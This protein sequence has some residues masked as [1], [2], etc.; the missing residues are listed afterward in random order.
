MH[1]SKRI[2]SSIMVTVFT[3]F[4]LMSITPLQSMAMV[5][6]T[7]TAAVATNPTP[8]LKGV[9]N[10]Y[11]LGDVVKFTLTSKGYKKT[12]SYRV[13]AVNT[14]TKKNIDVTKGYTKPML[15]AKTTTYQLKALAAGSYT[16]TAYVKVAGVKVSQ[17]KFQKQTFSVYNG[18]ALR[19]ANAKL[20]S[21]TV[22]GDLYIG[23]NNIT[24]SNTR[25][26]GTVYVNPGKNGTTN[27]NNIVA[28]KIKV[29]SGGV[30]SIHFN[31]VSADVLTVDSSSNV[32]VAATGTTQIGNTTIVSYAVLDSKGGTLGTVTIK[33]PANGGVPVVELRGIFPD[34]V[35]IDSNAKVNIT[36]GTDLSSLDIRS[37]ATVTAAVNSNV[38]AVKVDTKDPTAKVALNGEYNNVSVTKEAQVALGENTNIKGQLDIKAS[39]KLTVPKSSSVAKVEINTLSKDAKVDI[40]GST[41]GLIHVSSPANIALAANSKSNIMVDSDGVSIDAAAGATVNLDSKTYDVATTSSDSSQFTKV[42]LASLE[43]SVDDAIAANQ[44]LVV[45]QKESNK[46]ALAQAKK[47]AQAAKDALKNEVAQV[48]GVQL[49]NTDQTPGGGVDQ[50]ALDKAAKDAADAAAAADKAAADKVAAD[51]A[52]ADKAAADKAAKDAA[53]K[54]VKDAADKAAQDKAAKDAA[55]AAAAKA[56]AD[57]EAADAAARLAAAQQAAAD[58]AAYLARLQAAEQN[59]EIDAETAVAAAEQAKLV[60]A[61]NLIDAKALLATAKT[62]VAK[63]G[64]TNK[65]TAFTN[66]LNIVSDSVTALY[67]SLEKGNQALNTTYNSVASLM[68]SGLFGVFPSSDLTV[69][70]LSAPYGS[71]VTSTITIGSNITNYNDLY[72][73]KMTK[74]TGDALKN[75]ETQA[76]LAYD[77]FSTVNMTSNLGV[78]LTLNQVISLKTKS[79]GDFLAS[80]TDTTADAKYDAM[81]AAITKLSASADKTKLIN[82]A[83]LLA[84]VNKLTI[85]TFT[86]KSI[87]FNSSEVFNPTNNRTIGISDLKTFLGVSDLTKAGSVSVKGLKGSSITM[88]LTGSTG[89]DYTYTFNI[90]VNTK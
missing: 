18:T 36:A 50:A 22:N 80:A 41:I 85:G 32:R 27:L 60:T 12:V 77:F 84:S 28:G 20:A 88:V 35:I 53:D 38:E 54:A 44:A 72:V 5:K 17:I 29:M 1:K 56:A 52:A 37:A 63:V 76:A 3:S 65:V 16:L 23:A 58:R 15:A 47:D 83:P 21:K 19:K 31:T 82:I 61:Q 33:K 34:P 51:K 43:Q 79:L 13:I 25:V 40:D 48:G 62:A 9:V 86:V 73:G 59:A 6:K 66:R 4:S 71:S 26:K 90:A 24:V 7:K 67:T 14:K 74:V 2:L 8:V 46:A 10:E 39:A 81:Y 87:K 42:D 57:K 30:N 78:D 68:V 89:Y 69:S 55:D 45:A 11:N 70:P 49:G 64:D 75:L